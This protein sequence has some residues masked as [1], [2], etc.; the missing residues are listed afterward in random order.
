MHRALEA[1]KATL[2]VL[3]LGCALGMFCEWLM[4]GDAV[5]NR[6]PG[7][8]AVLLGGTLGIGAITWLFER[9]KRPPESK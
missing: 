2:F 3:G 4:H 1:M 9:R 8:A 7:I 6:I 5:L